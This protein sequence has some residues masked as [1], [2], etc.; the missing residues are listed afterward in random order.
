MSTA[1]S[2]PGFDSP[3]VGF[4]QPFEMLEACHSRVQRSLELLQKLLAHVQA[5]GHDAQSQS[6]ARDVL[7]YFDLA[8]PLHHDDEELNVFPVVLAHGTVDAVAA[9][10]T[11]QG[12]HRTMHRLWQSLREVLLAWSQPGATTG[13]DASMPG[14]VADFVGVYAQHIDTE[15]ELVY[16]QARI[17]LSAAQLAD[18]GAQMRARRQS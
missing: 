1:Q 10:H 6:A 16:P 17:Q 7:R 12:E 14:L 3:A 15:E 13:C 18:I 2:L 4:E 5:N 11:L 8:A 9:V